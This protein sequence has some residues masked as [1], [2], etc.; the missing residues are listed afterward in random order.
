MEILRDLCVK[1]T[2]DQSAVLA[3]TMKVDL[4]EIY[5]RNAGK[6]L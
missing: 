6:V 1:R 2:F 3:L 5:N 4:I